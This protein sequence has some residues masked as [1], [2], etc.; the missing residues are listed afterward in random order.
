MFDSLAVIESS[1][2]VDSLLFQGD[3]SESYL[4]AYA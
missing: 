1:I 3:F 4:R 2:V